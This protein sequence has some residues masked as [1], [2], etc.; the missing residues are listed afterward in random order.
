V[1]AS[2]SHTTQ[3]I[4]SMS[5][6]VF[7]RLHVDTVVLNP[8][9]GTKAWGADMAFLRAALA[10]AS[11]GGRVYSLHKSSTRA[12]IQASALRCDMALFML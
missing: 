2:H 3:G 7:S 1:Q 6:G 9:F 5:A 10:I 12:H 11:P 4:F 8:P